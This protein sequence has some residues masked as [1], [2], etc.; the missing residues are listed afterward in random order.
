MDAS[1]SLVDVTLKG[2]LELHEVNDYT[3]ELDKRF[4]RA[5]PPGVAYVL[6]IDISE[7]ALQSTAVIDVFRDYIAHFPKAERIAIV[8]GNSSARMQLNRILMRDY[9]R[10]FDFRAEA[11]TWLLEL[12]LGKG[13]P[14]AV[15]G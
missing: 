15:N 14:K 13:S 12:G 3:A 11:E 9:L 5:F 8:S 7:C 4:A 2:F 1:R 10:F 6:L